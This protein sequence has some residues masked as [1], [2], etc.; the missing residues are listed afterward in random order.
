MVPVI[1]QLAS[2]FA[3]YLVLA[4]AADAFE[5]SRKSKSILIKM[6]QNELGFARVMLFMSTGEYQNYDQANKVLLTMR[7]R[8]TNN[9]VWQNLDVTDN[10][11]IK[12][13]V[14]QGRMIR[15]DLNS[16]WERLSAAFHRGHG[17]M[18]PYLD[19]DSRNKLVNLYTNQRTMSRMLVEFERKQTEQ[20]PDELNTLRSALVTFIIFFAAGSTLLSF[21]LVISFAQDI[22]KRLDLIA[23]KANLLAV[24]I[25]VDPTTNSKAADEIAE[26][27]AIINAA[28]WTLK[29]AI[30]REAIVLNNAADILCSID[31]RL[32]FVAV[33]A[34]SKAS[35]GYEPG[36]LLGMALSNLLSADTIEGTNSSLKNLA[37]TEGEGRFENSVRCR[38]GNLKDFVWS[39]V[40]SSEQKVYFCVAHD[41]TEL[42]AVDRLKQHFLSVASH[43]LRAPLTAVSIN[44]SLLQ[45]GT[46]GIL[47]QK[48]VDE[49]ARVQL[50]SNR[51]TSLVNELLELDKLEAGKLILE[52]SS[53]GISDVCEAAKQSLF[54]VARQKSVTIITPSNDAIV[55]AEEKR[56]LQIIEN[57]VSNAIKFSPLDAV[58][59][60]KLTKFED[61]CEVSVSDQ[62][63]GIPLDQHELIFD[64]FRQARGLGPKQVEGSGLGLAVVKALVQSHGGTVGIRSASGH[65]STFWVRLPLA[66]SN[67]FIAEDL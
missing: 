26:L 11:E 24:D 15:R 20:Q 36:E 66:S 2:I 3:V 29:N 64:K 48:A 60:I 27:D 45:K 47:P 12:E 22:V 40:W 9:D 23:H 7:D 32:R 46:K 63:S 10:P 54:A 65:G 30:A 58:V 34:A 31:S 17:A 50:N 18:F 8:L 19:S 55:F 5:T 51:L 4:K 38:N 21:W 6:H 41:V 52:R 53:V 13:V 37:E 56:L 14:N 43:D 39:V 25:A 28:G 1:F 61:F 62:G 33:G 35:W 16:V 57:L 44:V 49:L 59:E 42:R 67:G